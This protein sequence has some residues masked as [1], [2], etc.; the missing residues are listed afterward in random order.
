MSKENPSPNIDVQAL[1]TPRGD[2]FDV[3]PKAVKTWLNNLPMANS[4][5]AGRLLFEALR[6]VNGLAVDPV[7]RFEFLDALRRPIRIIVQSLDH[8]YVGIPFPLPATNRRIADLAIAFLREMA[9]GYTHVVMQLSQLRGVIGLTRRPML[10]A[11]TYRA[12]LFR[13]RVLAK[14]FQIYAPYPQMLWYETHELFDYAKRSGIAGKAIDDPDNQLVKTRTIED[15]YKQALL[16][17]LSN[18]YRLRQG[19]VVK[20]CNALELWSPYCRLTPVTHSGSYPQGLFAIHQNSDEQPCYL[21][22]TNSGNGLSWVLDTT[23]LGGLLREQDAYLTGKQKKPSKTVLKALPPKFPKGLLERIMLS[24]GMM[25]IR[26]HSRHDASDTDR[27]NVALGLSALYYFSGGNEEILFEPIANTTELTDSSLVKWSS[28]EVHRVEHSS[29]CCRILDESAQGYRLAS[30]T[31]NS[32]RVQVGEL[33]G[34]H[35]PNTPDNQ[36]SVAAVRWMRAG[37]KEEI[38]IGVQL[39]ASSFKPITARVCNAEGHC[40]E[41]QAC[42]L[43]TSQDGDDRPPTLIAPNFFHNFA[44]RLL[45]TDGARKQVVSITRTVENTGAFTHFEFKRE[46]ANVPAAPAKVASASPVEAAAQTEQIPP[47]TPHPQRRK[48]ESEFE[49]IWNNL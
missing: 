38:E 34:V 40:G 32:L 36:W 21:E 41:H 5:E 7:Q 11:A 28:G 43:L 20:V 8:H 46:I 45:L 29:H 17:S 19:D 13:T 15:V 44:S 31:E 4:G 18:P 30:C 25:T 6:E 2:S 24:W 3:H 39:L 42:L 23:A 48:E 10:C 12:L 33:L 35:L 9:T 26:G 37:T 49:S 27:I 1:A 22:G 47:K 16:L 14:S